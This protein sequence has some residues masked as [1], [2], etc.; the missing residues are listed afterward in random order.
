MSTE[1]ARAF[2]IVAPGRGAIRTETLTAR[3][4]T[5]GRSRAV[6]RDQPR[7]RSDV[8][9]NRVPVSEYQRMRAPFQDGDFPARSSTGT[10]ASGASRM[11]RSG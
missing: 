11:V 7:H 3:R 5:G 2:W 9:Q 8:F 4:P 6:Q 10:P 1:E